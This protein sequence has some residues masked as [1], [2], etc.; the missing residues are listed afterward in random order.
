MS[1]H[2]ICAGKNGPRTSMSDVAFSSMNDVFPDREVTLSKGLP[3]HNCTCVH[4][5]PYQPF[6]PLNVACLCSVNEILFCA[7]A[8]HWHLLSQQHPHTIPYM[9]ANTVTSYHT[10]VHASKHWH[11]L[12][13]FAWAHASV[14][15]LTS[16]C[17]RYLRLYT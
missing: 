12:L 16:V 2:G 15:P 7:H 4:A 11:L 13:H 17:S 1:L 9:Q 5:T 10:H 8:L 14:W 3:L 6:H